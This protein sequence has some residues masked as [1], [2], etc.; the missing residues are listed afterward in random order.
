M[1]MNP[2]ESARSGAAVMKIV[3]RCGISSP[4]VLPVFS[5]TM[6]S[7]SPGF[8]P[9]WSWQITWWILGIVMMW[10]L[11]FKAEMATTNESRSNVPKR[12]PTSLS[13]KPKR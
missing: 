4:S 13:R 5:A 11:C 12:K 10:A 2:S 3:C 8:P 9:L 6:P 1:S 7:P